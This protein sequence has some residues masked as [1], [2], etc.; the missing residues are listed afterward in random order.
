MGVGVRTLRSLV[1][2]A[3]KKQPG[4]VWG[5]AGTEPAVAG[6]CF[7]HCTVNCSLCPSAFSCRGSKGCLR[8]FL[9][10]SCCIVTSP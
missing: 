8:S 3:G 9:C 7:S 10:T 1:W 6:G 4:A 5:A 2:L